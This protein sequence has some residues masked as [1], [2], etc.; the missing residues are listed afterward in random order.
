MQGD[1][2]QLSEVQQQVIPSPTKKTS[3]TSKPK[4]RGKGFQAAAASPFVSIWNDDDLSDYL[5]LPSKS[6]D[7]LLV[8]CPATA[9]QDHAHYLEQIAAAFDDYCTDDNTP[10]ESSDECAVFSDTE[11]EDEH[12]EVS[13]SATKKHPRRPRSSQEN[14]SGIRPVLSRETQVQATLKVETVHPAQHA[15]CISGPLM[16]WWP[17]PL[18]VQEHQWDRDTCEQGS[19]CRSKPEADIMNWWPL[20]TPY[21]CEWNEKFYE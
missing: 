21:S 15:E 10:H 13:R 2:F 20:A 5:Y 12:E 6:F 1:I 19:G 9:A 11:E 16:S 7:D 14:S 17:L 4:P 8:H 18:D 3:A